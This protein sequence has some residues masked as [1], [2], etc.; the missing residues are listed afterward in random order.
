MWRSVQGVV[1]LWFSGQRVNLHL[2]FLGQQCESGGTFSTGTVPEVCGL[3]ERLGL[4]FTLS[5]N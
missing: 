3:C 4:K 5:K 2:Q 1:L